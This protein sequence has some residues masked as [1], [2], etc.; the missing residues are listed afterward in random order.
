MDECPFPAK[1][2]NLKPSPAEPYFAS[3]RVEFAEQT[4]RGTTIVVDEES[5][6]NRLCFLPPEILHVA[7]P[8]PQSVILERSEGSRRGSFEDDTGEVC[9]RFTFVFTAGASPRP[10]KEWGNNLSFGHTIPP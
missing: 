8:T 2:S 9:N 10:T 1:R 7:T 3:L 6:T 5:P 4:S